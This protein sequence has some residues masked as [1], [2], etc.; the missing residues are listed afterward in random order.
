MYCIEVN[1]R[2]GT[3]GSYLVYYTT[4]TQVMPEM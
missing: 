3:L 4:N 1:I 2:D